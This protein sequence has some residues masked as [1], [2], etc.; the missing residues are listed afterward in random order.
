MEAQDNRGRRALHLAV[1]G[2]H[3]H[4][5]EGLLEHIADIEAGDREGEMALHWAAVRGDSAVVEYLLN[6]GAEIEAG[7]TTAAP[8]MQLLMDRDANIE[9]RDA[10]GWTALHRRPSS[11]AGAWCGHC[12]NGEPCWRRETEP[13][14]GAGTGGSTALQR[15]L[16]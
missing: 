1:I 7:A 13:D 16:Y 8:T 6:R 2:G 4:T 10:N 3:Q 5:V 11:T 14:D 15:S 12:W 9:A